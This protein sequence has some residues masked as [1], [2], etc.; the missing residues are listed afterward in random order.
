MHV[1]AI[2]YNRKITGVLRD[3]IS[4]GRGEISI[5]FAI[6]SLDPRPYNPVFFGGSQMLLR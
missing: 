1:E 2:W 3:P 6:H 4:Y 5:A